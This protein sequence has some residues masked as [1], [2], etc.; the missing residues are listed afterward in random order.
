[1][2]AGSVGGAPA[3]ATVDEADDDVAV[4]VAEEEEEA[5]GASFISV[6]FICDSLSDIAPHGPNSAIICPRRSCFLRC[7]ISMGLP[8]DAF[9][10]EVAAAAAAEAEATAADCW[11]LAWS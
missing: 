8:E 6:C 1:M 2:R 7:F 9:E 4:V 3:A 5:V 10:V 11:M